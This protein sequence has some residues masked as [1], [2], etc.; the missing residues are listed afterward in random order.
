MEHNL[1]KSTTIICVRKGKDVAMS[2]DGQ[3]T[4]GE[5]VIKSNAVKIRKL[6][7]E[8]VLAGFAGSAADSLAL[9]EK[10]EIKLE[11]FSGDLLKASVSLAKDWRLDKVLRQLE[12]MLIVADKKVT[13]LISGNGNIIEP[14]D[15]IA[16]IGSG[17][18]YARAAAI[19]FMKSNPDMSA[20]EIAQ[21]SIEI[22]SKICI[23]TN[24]Q[25]TTETL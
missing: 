23:Y 7:K 4:L 13:L 18:G 20:R 6:Y 2:G 16:V 12:A 14:E 19:A 9:L 21:A 22:A 17:A 11:E 3:I 8:T 1:W 24:S 15:N 25:I 5:M 10:F